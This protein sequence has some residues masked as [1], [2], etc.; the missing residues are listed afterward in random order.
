M[1]EC[2]PLIPALPVQRIRSF[3]NSAVNSAVKPKG[4]CVIPK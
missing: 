4:E 2:E 1:W 3:M